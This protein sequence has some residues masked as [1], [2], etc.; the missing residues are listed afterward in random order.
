MEE[1]RLVEQYPSIQGEGPRVGEMTQF[2]RFAGCD[3]RC[4]G[5]PCDTAFASNPKIW[6]KEGNSYKMTP[7]ELLTTTDG[8][9]ERSGAKNICLTGGEPFMQDNELLKQYVGSLKSK[10]YTIE[11]FSNGSFLYPSWALNDISFVMDWKLSGSGEGSTKIINRTI[12]ASRL[13]PKDSIKFVVT[14]KE[15][16]TEAK[17]IYRDLKELTP[18]TFWIGAAWDKVTNYEILSFVTKNKLPWKLNVQLHKF[19]WDPDKRGV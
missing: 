10:G 5:W 13:K 9:R 16:F 2:I 1:L 19:I 7:A 6:G 17:S 3:M 14:G 11:A 8:F 12:N 15:D 18:A 4:P